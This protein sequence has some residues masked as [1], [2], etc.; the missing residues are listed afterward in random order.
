[1][2]PFGG[3]VG[4]SGASLLRWDRSPYKA[5]SALSVERAFSEGSQQATTGV[6]F[7]TIRY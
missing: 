5:L 7:P 1:M 4:L 2:Q 6:K 3:T